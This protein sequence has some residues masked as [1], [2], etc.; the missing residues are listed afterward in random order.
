MKKDYFDITVVLDRSGSMSSVKNDT[1]GGLNSFIESQKRDKNGEVTFTLLQFDNEFDYVYKALK[2]SDVKGLTDKTFEP[3]GST[4][5]LD[6]MGRAI[7]DTGERLSA[8]K[9]EDRP[10]KVIF[11]VLTDGHENASQEF[12]KSQIAQMVKHQQEVYSWEFI[13]LAA[14]QDAVLSGRE[15]GFTTGKSMSYAHNAVGTKG[16]FES[17]SR[18]SSN[19]RS[20]NYNN[21]DFTEE[22][23][24]LQS[25]NG[26][27]KRT[28]TCEVK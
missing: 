14:N 3:R 11:V 19:Y 5:L 10:E 4:A 21:T 15:Y 25:D 1:I 8:M 2:L 28:V 12:N 13:F 23:R 27:V 16:A 17:I 9:E 6:A 22:E 18:I 26:A 24:K 20:K 7:R